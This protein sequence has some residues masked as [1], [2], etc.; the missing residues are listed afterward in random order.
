MY[1]VALH[2]D[3]MYMLSK[4]FLGNNVFNYPRNLYLNKLFDSC[5]VEYVK[6][7]IYNSSRRAV[8]CKC[9]VV[10]DLQILVW[11][12]HVISLKLLLLWSRIQFCGKLVQNWKIFLKLK[13][14]LVYVK[15]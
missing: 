8:S 7:S 10:F 6:N 11:F 13:L 9:C 5:N 12:C 2:F 1:T 14:G 4:L 3:L 15:K